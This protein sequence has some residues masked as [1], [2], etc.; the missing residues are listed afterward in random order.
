MERD[1]KTEKT[2]QRSRGARQRTQRENM[3]KHMQRNME[4]KKK[5]TIFSLSSFPNSVPRPK[6][7]YKHGYTVPL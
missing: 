1:G 3:N 4:G 5:E 6:L 7:N 2:V